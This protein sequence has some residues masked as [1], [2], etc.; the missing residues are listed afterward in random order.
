[1]ICGNCGKQLDDDSVFCTSCGMKLDEIQN[2]K[3]CANCGNELDD[4]AVF[5]SKCGSKIQYIED[6]TISTENS[7]SAE[8]E[9]TETQIVAKTSDTKKAGLFL[10]VAV[11]IAFILVFYL[12]TIE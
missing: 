3:F 6:K 7:H 9:K 8:N 2:K 10:T 5:C 1:M 4:D 11:L 12:S